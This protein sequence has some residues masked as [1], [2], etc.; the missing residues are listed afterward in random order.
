MIFVGVDPGKHGALA[1]MDG[2]RKR[3]EVHDTPLLADGTFDLQAAYELMR[4]ACWEGAAET[5]VTIEDTVSIPHVAQGQRF[6]PASDKALH[7]SLGAWCALAAVFRIRPR[8]VVPKTWKRYML[9]GVAN[10]NEAEAK[11]LELRFQGH[12]IASRVRGARGGLKDGRVD[13]LFLAEYGRM[14]WKLTGGR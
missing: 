8:L 13:A 14:A 6:L 3:V 2:E 10:D 12:D 11:A 1:L 9:A 7:F 5:V 4:R